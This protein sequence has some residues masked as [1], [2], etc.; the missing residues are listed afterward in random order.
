[1]VFSVKSVVIEPGSIVDNIHLLLYVVKKA[2][3]E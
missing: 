3:K 2:L 1:M